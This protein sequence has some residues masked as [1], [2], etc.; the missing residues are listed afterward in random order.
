[1]E[2]NNK[3]NKNKVFFIGIGGISMS[4]LAMLTL[5]S[6]A[7]VA[8][9]DT[10]KS[11]ITCK[12]EK[13]CTIFY[14][15][16]FKNIKSFKPNLV[17]YSGA[18]KKDNPELKFAIKNKIK[19]MDRADYLG[20][21][22]E[23]Y[24]NVIAISGTHGKTST[25]A[26]IAEIFC[27]AKLNPTVHV[28]G[29]VKNIA[30]NLLIGGDKYFI[31]EACEYKKSFEHIKSTCGVVTNIE[32]DH[33]DCYADF[34]DLKASFIKFSENS[35]FCV[36]F[37]NC[38]ILYSVKNKE[39]YVCGGTGEN[40]V[41]KNLKQHMSGMY[42][43]DVYENGIYL[44]NFKLNVM[45]EYNV[46]NALLAIAVA[47]QFN[48]SISVIYDALLS[49]NGV[50]RRN[51]QLG[52]IN[53]TI[54][55]ADYCHHPTEIINSIQNFKQIYK[56]VLCVF[57]PHTYSRTKNL[58]NEFTTCF[59]GVKK[60][61]IFKTYPAREPYLDCGSETALFCKV[62]NKNKELIMEEQEL[63]ERI[64]ELSTNY[65][66]IIVLGAGDVYD[67]VKNEIKFD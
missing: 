32:R 61:I 27:K 41:A 47:R 9:S 55:Y 38:P 48:I 45:G 67:I 53:G 39:I 12:L 56:N 62:K 17:V 59:K 42:S 34:N 54:V 46:W 15:H 20:L 18:I 14:E 23:K 21:I 43:F 10:K 37:K 24:D 4:A 51:E 65:K 40:Y 6:G 66:C 31:T 22:C 16:N 26:M 7:L 60:L 29:E 1:M 50:L 52:S 11:N 30:G 25:T 2:N 57:Q 5:N 63:L 58:M 19:V 33:M 36:F 64:K 35:D 8:G 13:D 3:N 44:N 49:F 28:G